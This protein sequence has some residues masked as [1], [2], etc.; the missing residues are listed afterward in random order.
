MDISERGLDFITSFEGKHKNI[1]DGRYKAYLDKIAVPHVWTIYCGLTKGVY[2]GMIV[3]EEEGDRLFRKELAVCEDH[4]ERCVEVPLNQNQFDALVSFTYNCGPGALQTSTMLSLLNEGKYETVPAQLARWCHAGG[5]KVNGLVRRRAAEGALF[6][7][8]MPEDLPIP[9]GVDEEPVPQ[10]PQRVEEAPAGR[11][12][13]V[14][15][16]SWTL[17]GAALAFL[18]TLTTG[19][20]QAYDWA[21]G[22]AKEAGPEVLS[23]KTTISP[24]S[25]LLKATPTVLYVVVIVG[26]VIVVA[27]KIS[28]HVKGKAV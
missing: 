27:R 8:P 16:Q 10:M 26:L 19:I 4:V 13:E 3:T 17:R 28:D 22:V 24:F 21:F 11:V 5:K 6:L 2:E 9:D 23:L 20:E 1:G 15:T 14:I 18:G 7:D 25:P 12:T